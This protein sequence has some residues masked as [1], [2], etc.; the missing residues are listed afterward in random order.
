MS[1]RGWEGWPTFGEASRAT[2]EY[3]DAGPIGDVLG[4]GLVPVPFLIGEKRRVIPLKDDIHADRV[5]D[6]ELDLVLQP[7]LGLQGPVQGALRAQDSCGTED[8]D[9]VQQLL[10]GG[11]PWTS[12]DCASGCNYGEDV[13]EEE[14]LV[15]RVEDDD[16]R[17]L[18]PRQYQ[19]A[20]QIA[21]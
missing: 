21:V 4:P 6:Q 20:A 10:D 8:L 7:T 13:G 5:L 17:W 9:P 15:F 1:V 19:V 18:L 2:R 16:I 12:G 14:R 11:L 3:D